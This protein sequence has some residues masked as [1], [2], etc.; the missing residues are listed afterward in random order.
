[1]Y[2][3]ITLLAA[4][5]SASAVYAAPVPGLTD[6]VG[7]AV[8]GVVTPLL[9]ILNAEGQAV[10][11]ILGATGNIVGG[12]A[13]AVGGLLGTEAGVV[14]DN[15][16]K[17]TVT[18][19]LE[20]GAGGVLAPVIP[21]VVAEGQAVGQVLGATGNIVGGTLGAVLGLV[22]NEAGVIHSNLRERTILGGVGTAVD[23][24]VAPL[25]PILNAEGQAVGEVVGA[26]GNIVGGTVGAVEG[27]LN[28]IGGAVLGNLKKRTVTGGV[29][30][31][32]DGVVAPLLP[33]L[34]AEGQAVGEI[35]GATGNI[36]GGSVGAVGGLLNGIGGAVLGNL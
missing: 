22:G 14:H 13:G 34:N 33:I 28:G 35:V 18:D 27:L 25:L 11:E 5:L 17:R 4:L 26:T 32:V 16:R 15:L 29:A 20:T 23:G 10:G 3:L 6:G 1:M 21:I 2:K 9:P 36:V 24:V 30:T 19:G 31:G 7:A 8:N 12:T